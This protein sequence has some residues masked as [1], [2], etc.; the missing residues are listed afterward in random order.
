MNKESIPNY[1]S[2]I[3][4]TKNSEY[5]GLFHEKT[6]FKSLTNEHFLKILFL[7]KIKI[8]ANKFTRVMSF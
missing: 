3:I 5:K 2:Y 6:I 4:I 1:D 7:Q 8:K